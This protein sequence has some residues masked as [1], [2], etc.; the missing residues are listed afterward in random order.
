M[1]TLPL[2]EVKAKLGRLIDQVAKTD[3]QVMITRNGRPVG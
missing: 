1:K 3:E 2:A